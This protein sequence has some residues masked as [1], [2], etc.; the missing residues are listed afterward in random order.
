MRGVGRTAFEEIVRR[1]P[2]PWI[3]RGQDENQ[4]ALEFWRRVIPVVSPAGFGLTER[5]LRNPCSSVFCDIC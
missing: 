2:D 3:I 4:A 5:A 1:F